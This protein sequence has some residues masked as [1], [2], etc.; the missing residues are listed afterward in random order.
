MKNK[1]FLFSAI[2]FAWLTCLNAQEPVVMT[3]N[4]KQITKSE[5]EAVYRKN[6]GKEVK[7]NPKTVKEYVDLFSLFKSKVFEAES[8]GLDTLTTF[9]TELGGYRKQ[10]AAPYLTDKNT[11]ESLLTEAY[12]RLQWEV[13]ASHILIKLDEGALP[14]DTLEAFTRATLIRN[15]TTGK[16]PTTA[17]IA[18]YDRLLKASTEVAKL[19]KGK[20]SSLYKLR[21]ASVKNLAEYYKN[22]KDKFQD[23]A[24]KT[25]D[26]ASA[27]QNKGDLNYFTAFDM[28]YPFEN[29]AFN[30]KVGDVSNVVRTKYGY[31]IIKVYDKRKSRGEITVSH[32]MANSERMQANRI[33]PMPKPRY[34]S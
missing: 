34:S 32:I 24:P 13:R 28:V 15:A 9:K 31:H 3:I 26:D 19:L 6:N 29:A 4:G 21:Y 12:D 1:G 8:M 22:A 17:E 18:N 20:D 14:K 7:S 10:L 33:K 30:T 27:L 5:F 23:I 25:S 16:L 11:N 2:S